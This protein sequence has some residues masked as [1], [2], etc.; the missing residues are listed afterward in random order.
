MSTEWDVYQHD[1]LGDVF[2]CLYIQ[3]YVRLR[4]E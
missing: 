4:V 3:Q 1:L 2:V